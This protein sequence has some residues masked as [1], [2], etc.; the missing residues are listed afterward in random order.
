MYIT[1]SGEAELCISKLASLFH[2]L[3][4]VGPKQLCALAHIG[5]THEAGTFQDM[6]IVVYSVKFITFLSY[7]DVIV[8]TSREVS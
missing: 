3:P 1:L 8:H 5:C 7:C 2:Y 6:N 4:C